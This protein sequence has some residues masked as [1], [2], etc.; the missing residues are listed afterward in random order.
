MALFLKLLFGIILLLALMAM[1]R[2]FQMRLA[3]SAHARALADGILDAAPEEANRQALADVLRLWDQLDVEKQSEL[4]RHL[5]RHPRLEDLDLTQ[6][7]VREQ[8]YR[9]LVGI[10]ADKSPEK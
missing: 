1:M 9:S 5:A 6:G 8:T 10:S 2:R 4:A 7:D 3:K